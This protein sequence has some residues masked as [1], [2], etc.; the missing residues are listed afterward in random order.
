MSIIKTNSSEYDGNTL[1][2]AA[3]HAF[4]KKDQRDIKVSHIGN[5]TIVSVFNGRAWVDYDTWMECGN[6]NFLIAE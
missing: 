4:S 2:A 3:M 6:H 1:K 5:N